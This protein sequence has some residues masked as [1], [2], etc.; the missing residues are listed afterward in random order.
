MRRNMLAIVAIGM[1]GLM[2]VPAS[3]GTKV[4]GGNFDK[5]TVLN[6]CTNAGGV[7][8]SGGAGGAYGC[9]TNKGTV[10]CSA[11]GKCT[12]T[13]DAC[14]QAMRGTGGIKGV[15]QGA[16]SAGAAKATSSGDGKKSSGDGKTNVGRMPPASSGVKQEQFG[17]NAVHRNIETNSG[18]SGGKR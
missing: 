1:L 4:L 16:T 10:T 15:L 2:A 9:S 17:T 8:F 14:S 3:A 11:K 13:C 12:G 6:D 7:P 18:S 5:N